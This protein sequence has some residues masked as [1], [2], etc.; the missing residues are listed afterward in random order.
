MTRLEPGFT[1]IV[2]K[3]RKTARA[4]LDAAAE[5]G[6]GPEVVRTTINSFVVPDAVYEQAAPALEADRPIQTTEQF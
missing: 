2:G 5:L 1:A 3:D 4:L 6:H